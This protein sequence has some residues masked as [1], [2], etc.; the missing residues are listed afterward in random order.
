MSEFFENINSLEQKVKDKK[1]QRVIIEEESDDKTPN[2]IKKR[3]ELHEEVLKIDDELGSNFENINVPK[4]VKEVEELLKLVPKKYKGVIKSGIPLF[5]FNF[6]NKISGNKKTQNTLK[7]KIKGFLQKYPKEEEKKDEEETNQEKIDEKKEKVVVTETESAR[8][9][10]LNK[11]ILKLLTK[12]YGKKIDD[13]QALLKDFKT[14]KE[15][16]K[17][18]ITLC[19]L[20]IH[21]KGWKSYENLSKLL[22]DISKILRTHIDN[23]DALV[24]CDVDLKHTVEINL[25]NYLEYLVEVVEEKEYKNF[26]HLLENLFFIQPEMVA[27]INM[28]F[29]YFLKKESTETQNELYRLVYMLRSTE[30]DYQTAKNYFLKHSDLYD[31]NNKYAIYIVHEMGVA[32]YRNGDNFFAFM[33]LQDCYFN[34]NTKKAEKD[35]SER[36]LLVL[37]IILE[38]TIVDEP[39]YDVFINNISVLES[40]Q[41]LIKSTTNYKSEIFRAY[42]YLESFCYDECFNILKESENIN[43][44]VY[45]ILKSRVLK[46]FNALTNEKVMIQ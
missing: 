16:L 36:C 9:E 46:N 17:I 42:F 30:F 24:F 31:L 26:E 37:T 35:L 11:T 32:A 34:S 18:Y 33:V 14:D 43:D 3:N 29:V 41:N 8:N 12:N 38:E 45:F 1:K 4:N 22:L 6:L 19:S 39:F 7:N 44:D 20:R 25:K 21:E 5:L 13:V 15:V 40:N 28:F 23:E 2:K 10:R 27:K